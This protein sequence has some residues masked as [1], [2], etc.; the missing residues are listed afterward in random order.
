MSDLKLFHLV[1]V[2]YFKLFHLVYVLVL[3]KHKIVWKKEHLNLQNRWFRRMIA[4]FYW[5]EKSSSFLQLRK[6]T[7]WF[8]AEKLFL[9]NTNIY[10]LG[11]IIQQK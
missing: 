7:S 9:R 3:E 1:Y 11:I 2:I 5:S 6:V 10:A 4:N 8:S